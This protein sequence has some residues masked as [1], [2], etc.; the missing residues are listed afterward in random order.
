MSIHLGGSFDYVFTLLDFWIT[1]IIFHLF[2]IILLL[3]LVIHQLNIFWNCQIFFKILANHVKKL[4][5]TF[6]HNISLFSMMLSLKFLSIFIVEKNWTKE[7][8]IITLMPNQHRNYDSFVNS[9]FLFDV[10]LSIIRIEMFGKDLVFII[11]M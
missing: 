6:K 8:L 4:N 1:L 10:L 9:R 7:I 2:F 5:E 11:I 3:R